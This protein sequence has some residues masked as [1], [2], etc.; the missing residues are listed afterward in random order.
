MLERRSQLNTEL[1]R[2]DAEAERL[3]RAVQRVG[4]AAAGSRSFTGAPPVVIEDS[5]RLDARI[6]RL[7]EEMGQLTG[8]ISGH[9]LDLHELE[10]PGQRRALVL[11]VL[12]LVVIA[13]VAIGVFLAVR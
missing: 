10:R 13:S 11:S 12:L 2:L 3:A 7:T 4:G 8:T 6:E 9:E 1:A 5:S